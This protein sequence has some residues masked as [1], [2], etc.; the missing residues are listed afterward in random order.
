MSKFPYQIDTDAEL[1]PIN[2]DITQMGGEAINALRDAVIKLQQTLGVGIISGGMPSLASRLNILLTADGYFTPSLLTNLGIVTAPVPANQLAGG[3][4]ESQ[5]ILDHSTVDLYNYISVLSNDVNLAL[6]WISA[7]GVKLEPHLMGFM[8]RHS[9]PQIDVTENPAQYLCNVFNFTGNI[10]SPHNPYIGA[11]AV[12]INPDGYRDNSSAYIMLNDLNNELL[13]HQWAD[14]TSSPIDGYEIYTVGGASYPGN[15]G[16]TASGVYIDPSAFAHIPQEKNDVQLFANYM[17]DAIFSFEDILENLFAN[18][19]SRSSSSFV[20]NDGYDGYGQFIVPPTPVTAFLSSTIPVDDGYAGDDIV[21]FNPISD[22]G[23]I[24]DSQFALV[25]IGDIL[26]INYGTGVEAS[27]VIKEK[28]YIAPTVIGGP[29]YQVRIVGKNLAA[30]DGYGIARID[31]PLFNNNKSGVLAVAPAFMPTSHLL[32]SG[33]ALPPGLIIGNPQGAQIVGSGFNPNQFDSSHYNLYL[34]LY[35]TGDPSNVISMLPIDVTGDQGASPGKYTLDYIVE[36]TNIAFRQP[37]YNYRFIA[38]SHEGQFGIMLADS[39]NNASFSIVGFDLDGSADGYKITYG[40]NNVI[41]LGAFGVH[42]GYVDLFDPLGFGP[43]NANIAS[44]P[45]SSTR[46]SA[47]TA[48]TYPTRIFV[49][50]KANNFYLNGEEGSSLSTFAIPEVSGGFV[51]QYGD[52]YWIAT[53]SVPNPPWSVPGSVPTTYTIN[54]PNIASS[55]SL[56]PGKTIVVQQM[57]G[58]G[59][60]VD[61]G[62]F[63]IASVASPCGND[64]TEITTYDSSHNNYGTTSIPS[65]AGTQVLIYAAND[66]LL[67]NSENSSDFSTETIEVSKRHFEIYIDA[68]IE[69][70]YALERARILAND[71]TTFADGTIVYSDHDYAP[72]INIV[73]VSPT[74]RGAEYHVINKIT[75]K[76]AQYYPITG[77]YDAVLGQYDGTT[78]ISLG[79]PVSGARIGQ[80]TRFYDRNAIDYVDIEL[81]NALSISSHT[82]LIDIQLFPT[83]ALDKED[84][85]LAT[86]QLDV[87]NNYIEYFVDQ[88]QF[89]NISEEQLSSSVLDYIARPTQLLNENGIIRG[90]TIDWPHPID[91]PNTFTVSGGIAVVDGTIVEVNNQTVIIPAIYESISDEFNNSVPAPSPPSSGVVNQNISW[92]VCINQKGQVELIASTDFATDSATIALYTNSSIALDQDRLF[93]VINPNLTSPTPYIVRSAYF[94]DLVLNQKDLVPIAIVHAVSAGN[95]PTIA[96][97]YHDTISNTYTS[98]DDVRRYVSGGYGGLISPFVLSGLG[99]FRTIRSLNAWLYQLNNYVSAYN[100]VSN[101]VVVKGIVN[102][103]LPTDAMNPLIDFTYTYPMEFVG[104]GGTLLFDSTAGHPIFWNTTFKRLNII[105]ADY[106]FFSDAALFQKQNVKFED[107]TLTFLGALPSAVCNTEFKNCTINVSNPSAFVLGSNVIFDNCHF[108]YTYNAENDSAYDSANLVN[109]SNGL[110]IRKL[111]VDEVLENVK[112][113]GCTFT[114]TWINH[115]PFINIQTKLEAAN[116]AIINVNIASNNFIHSNLSVNDM[117]AVIAFTTFTA[118][119]SGLYQYPRLIDVH[120]DNNICNQD[121]LIIIGCADDPAT[122]KMPHTT[123]PYSTTNCSI[124]GNSIGTIGYFIAAAS[125]A[126]TDKPYGL[127]IANNTCHLITN[128]NND[129]YYIPFLYNNGSSFVQNVGVGTGQANIYENVANWIIVGACSKDLLHVS[130]I[131]HGVNIFSNRLSPY[132]ASYL[133]NF[134]NITIDPSNSIAATTPPNV[135][136]MILADAIPLGQTQSTISNNITAQNI[137]LPV[138]RYVDSLCCFNNALI[139]GNII[140]GCATAF[141]MGLGN[142]DGA[143]QSIFITG[144]TINKGAAAAY[145]NYGDSD[146]IVVINNMF[147]GSSYDGSTPTEFDGPVVINDDLTLR[148]ASITVDDNSIIILQSGTDRDGTPIGGTINASANSQIAEYGTIA[149]FSGSRITTTDSTNIQYGAST[150][151]N[152][153]PID[154]FPEFSTP[155]IRYYMQPILYGGYGDNTSWGFDTSHGGIT[156]EAAVGGNT[157]YLA[158]NIHNQADLSSVTLNYWRN[159]NGHTISSPLTMTLY[160]YDFAGNVTNCGTATASSPYYAYNQQLVLTPNNSLVQP[161]DNSAYVYIL[162]ITDESTNETPSNSFL[163][164]ELYFTNIISSIWA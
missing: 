89:G 34:M 152:P 155:K 98:F 114:N 81:D 41:G 31:K 60:Y 8:F 134:Q 38:F 12:L 23:Y 72:L 151:D 18:G 49:P 156:D 138:Y 6:A 39:Y 16:H 22:S 71:S 55:T 83:T 133:D 14:G 29:I 132:S 47:V 126:E 59:S 75:F 96:V 77:T 15:Y 68:R 76:L 94:A 95:S 27:F 88:R 26:R 52:G 69:T 142:A 102:I 67:F 17:D 9:L 115:Y 3:I 130:V 129:G 117:R 92:F 20:L 50:L 123:A 57:D 162:A 99:S 110:I 64:I 93:Y 87:P 48:Y 158:L 124:S 108:L 40:N 101:T 82:A 66:S 10:A 112:I 45:Y 84:M 136:I 137:S 33:L 37:G 128:L 131:G 73:G 30:T 86:C 65:V 103:A 1:P 118:A 21:Q 148:N 150:S 91:N 159:D 42:T 24:F 154:L 63:I 125:Y 53:T 61:F 74:L 56:A 160:Q 135:G 11:N 139:T 113:T 105:F 157:W 19:V 147:D 58:Y 121:Q 127:T 144:N 7:T 116:T 28:T 2:D 122:G 36:Q 90:L 120:I 140:N 4:T 70:T 100:P 13:A 145:I 78:F 104:D 119:G 54:W 164:V 51:D 32:Q 106:C 35:P 146:N 79:I 163:S 46:L 80:V 143:N 43:L 62:R 149:M 161:L 44:P 109:A 107:C 85:L 153:M 141:C 97:V 25:R 5:L 111:A